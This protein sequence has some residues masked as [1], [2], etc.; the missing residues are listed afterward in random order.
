MTYEDSV[1]TVRFAVFLPYNETYLNELMWI[2][3]A[4]E[5]DNTRIW[6]GEISVTVINTTFSDMVS[7]GSANIYFENFLGAEPIGLYR[8]GHSNEN[9]KN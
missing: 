2:G 9:V 6:A 4:V 3:A 1:I 7:S 5:I 8:D